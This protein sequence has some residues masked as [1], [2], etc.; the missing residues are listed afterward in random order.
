MALLQNSSDGEIVAMGGLEV[1]RTLIPSI[2]QERTASLEEITNVF[3]DKGRIANYSDETILAFSKY[4]PP[5]HWM[6]E[7]Q[8]FV[9]F[10]R[11]LTAVRQQP[12]NF[13]T[14]EVRDWLLSRDV[15]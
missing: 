6:I 12:E 3:S 14:G 11:Q 10:N 1:F 9:Y 2:A 15:R 5:I 13:M 7:R 4:Y 8:M